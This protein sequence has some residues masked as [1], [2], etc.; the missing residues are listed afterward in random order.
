MNFVYGF[1]LVTL[2]VGLGFVFSAMFNKTDNEEASDDSLR[3]DFIDQQHMQVI[4][5]DGGKAVAVVTKR[6]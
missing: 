3:L 4:Q 2:G 6:T 5:V 1:M